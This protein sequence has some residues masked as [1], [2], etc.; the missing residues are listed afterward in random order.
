MTMSS[1]MHSGPTSTSCLLVFG[2]SGTGK[3]ALLKAAARELRLNSVI[4]AKTI[5]VPCRSIVGCT[6]TQVL[7]FLGYVVSM[8][9]LFMSIVRNHGLFSGSQ[10][11]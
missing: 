7:Q 6:M 5:F 11:I 9:F 1:P 2:G 10:K 8:I 3:T 4:L